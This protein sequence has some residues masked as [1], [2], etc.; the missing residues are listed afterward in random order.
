MS[1]CVQCGSPKELHVDGVLCPGKQ[2][3][4]ASMDLPRGKTCSDCAHIRFCTGFIGDVAANTSCDWFPIR[5]VPRL[6]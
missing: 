6:A 3:T 5:F 2:T 1:R 4:F